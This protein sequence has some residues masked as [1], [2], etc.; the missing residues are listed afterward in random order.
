MA[1]QI[2]ELIVKAICGE[3]GQPGTDQ[4]KPTVTKEE[5]NIRLSYTQRKRII[6]DCAAEVMDRIKKLNEF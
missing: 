5:G 1:I 4:A 2:K 3:K 6:D